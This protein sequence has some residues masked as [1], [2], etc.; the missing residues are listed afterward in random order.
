MKKFWKVFLVVV[1]VLAILG[2]G[3]AIVI[4]NMDEDKLAVLESNV[5]TI[6]KGDVLNG[7]VFHNDALNEMTT[8]DLDELIEGVEPIVFSTSEDG[9]KIQS[10]YPILLLE[11]DTCGA[12]YKDYTD[13]DGEPTDPYGLGWMPCCYSIVVIKTENKA[14]EEN[15]IALRLIFGTLWG[16]GFYVV[17]DNEEIHLSDSDEAG[18]IIENTKIDDCCVHFNT[19]TIIDDQT[20]LKH[21]SDKEL[22][23]KV[24]TVNNAKVLKKYIGGIFA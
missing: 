13:D 5:R 18:V 2:G 9:N 6:K 22:N 17:R 14:S 3:T 8:A 24:H 1:L 4:K 10:I 23:L 7:Y 11:C 16:D 15:E 20:G 21:S 19:L 12:T